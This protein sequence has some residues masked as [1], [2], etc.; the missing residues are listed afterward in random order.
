MEKLIGGQL[1]TDWPHPHYLK[2]YQNFL[3]WD[4]ADLKRYT[5]LGYWVQGQKGDLIAVHGTGSLTL[6]ATPDIRLGRTVSMAQ[7]INHAGEDF[8]KM[9]NERIKK[10]QNQI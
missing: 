4:A 1:L 2:Q 10:L 5:P 3:A 6:S 8:E 9:R 7:D